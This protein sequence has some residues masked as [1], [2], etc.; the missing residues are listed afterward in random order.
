MNH[1]PESRVSIPKARRIEQTRDL[2]GD[3]RVDGYGWLRDLDNPETLDYLAA[4]RSF[5]GSST[6]H[7][8][9]LVDGLAND[10]AARVPDADWGVSYARSQ[11]VY[12][13]RT[14]AGGEYQQLWRGGDL[15]LLDPATL[16]GE[17]AYIEVGVSLVSPDERLLAYS[18]D[19]TGDEV[20]T[21][22]FRDLETA[23]P[24]GEPVDLAD[25][26][27]RSYYGGAWSADS[28][29]FFYTVHDE[30]Y[31]PYQVWRHRVGTPVADDVLVLTEPDEQYDLDVRA[32]RSGD[33]VVIDAANR[34]TSEV[35]LVD[36][37]R[38][39]EPAARVSNRGGAGWSTPASTSGHPPATGSSSSPTTA[40]R[41]SG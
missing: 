36:A 39:A 40:P 16:K 4:E 14:P 28:T 32:T 21:L 34:D 11:F 1:Y 20:Y 15:L 30:A 22:R 6:A 26:I 10:M 5:Y 9:P 41:S 18:V 8:R 19:R 17:S 33:L 13:T 2:H 27:P 3:V 38:P 35:W 29:T 23:S 31:R 24:D 25:E 12:Y 7:L 37:H